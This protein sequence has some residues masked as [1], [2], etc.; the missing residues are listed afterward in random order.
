[1]FFPC[2][3]IIIDP[4]PTFWV[5]YCNCITETEKNQKMQRETTSDKPLADYLL[6]IWFW[7]GIVA[8]AS[9]EAEVLLFS[10]AEVSGEF[11]SGKEAVGEQSR[12]GRQERARRLFRDVLCLK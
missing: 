12:G 2:L 6:F 9:Q 7:F 3:S 11:P 4:N 8:E 1:M 5:I 10:A